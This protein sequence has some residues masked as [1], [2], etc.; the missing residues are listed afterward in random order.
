MFL[1]ISEVFVQR[2]VFSKPTD[3][4][5]SIAYLSVIDNSKK[6]IEI[7][8]NNIVFDGWMFASS[9]ALNAMEHPVYDLVLI[10]CKKFKTQW[11]E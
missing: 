9:P 2:C 10:E 7:K 1:T 4:T 8:K 6:E 5:E 11:N 3:T